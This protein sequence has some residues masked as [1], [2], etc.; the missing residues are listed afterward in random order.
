[1]GAPPD[2][3]VDDRGLGEVEADGEGHI[4]IAI[5]T[6]IGGW[7]GDEDR[8]SAVNA[9]RTRVNSQTLVEP[10]VS[11]MNDRKWDLTDG[12]SR[13][14]ERCSRLF[15]GGHVRIVSNP[16]GSGTPAGHRN[17]GTFEKAP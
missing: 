4:G 15:S 13:Q 3:E 11:A 16:W 10:D 7:G 9:V 17:R 8:G 12:R 14:V 1:M 2:V 6:G 5:G